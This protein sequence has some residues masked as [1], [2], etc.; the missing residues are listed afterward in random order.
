MCRF[1]SGAVF[2][3][4][5]LQNYSYLLRLD[6]DSCFIKGTELSLFKWANQKGVKYG[7]IKSAIQW[8]HPKVSENFKGIALKILFNIKF[9]YF[10]RCLLLP[11]ERMY[12]TNFEIMY[13]PFFNSNDWQKF[14][15]EIDKTGG[16]HLRRW[17][18]A[19]FR[20]IG[21]NS[22]S[23]KK[24]RAGIPPGFIYKHGGTFDSGARLSRR[25]YFLKNQNRLK[26]HNE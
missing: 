21:V 7:Y 20:Y 19:I 11:S 14:Y 23:N 9:I 15:Q 5:I 3:L 25:T 16:F 6:T 1:F 8:D 17:G 26:K 24:E 4:P 2:E 18:D 12:Y 13:L 10:L 22:M